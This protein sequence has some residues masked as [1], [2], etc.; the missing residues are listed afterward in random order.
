MCDSIIVPF[1]RTSM[2]FKIYSLDSDS[3]TAARMILKLN[4]DT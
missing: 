2:H 1:N 4:M 3:Q